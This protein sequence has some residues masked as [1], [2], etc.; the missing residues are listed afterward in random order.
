M[1]A[2]AWLVGCAAA[3]K[4][5]R[6]CREDVDRDQERAEA[7]NADTGKNGVH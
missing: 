1:N 5:T 4:A 6:G 7:K 3:D 2:L